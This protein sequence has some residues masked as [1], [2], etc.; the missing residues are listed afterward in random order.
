MIRVMDS[1]GRAWE[2]S[3]DEGK[4]MWTHQPAF[5]YPANPT[6]HA[7]RFGVIPVKRG[8]RKRPKYYKIRDYEEQVTVASKL[9]KREARAMCDLMNASVGGV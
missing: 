8:K 2:S 6:N 9:N 7:E 4:Q 1:Q 5:L 3:Y